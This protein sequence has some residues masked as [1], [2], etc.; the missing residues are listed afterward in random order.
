MN[1][2]FL[3]HAHTLSQSSIED[4]KALLITYPFCPLFR[5]IALLKA[6]EEKHPLE[7]DWLETTSI[8]VPDRAYLFQ[9]Y[10]AGQP[11][12]NPDAPAIIRTTL[13]P[14]SDRF[15]TPSKKAH[16]PLPKTSFASWATTKTKPLETVEP[17]NAPS[18][19]EIEE[20]DTHE[21]P[22]DVQDEVRAA[23]LAAKS[24]TKDSEIISETLAKVLAKQGK[25]VQAIEIY[26]KLSLKFPEKKAYFADLIENLTH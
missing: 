3:L 1:H 4:M 20:K 13:R 6:K 11:S 25:K 10:R 9:I 18:P 22:T 12:T 17:I 23:R 24:I 15:R 19:Q 2:Q 21:S 16:P 7:N 8:Y 26:R 5:V 14:I